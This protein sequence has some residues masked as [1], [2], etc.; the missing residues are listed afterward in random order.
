VMTFALTLPPATFSGVGA[1]LQ[2]LGA[3]GIIK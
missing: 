3:A 2:G 1:I